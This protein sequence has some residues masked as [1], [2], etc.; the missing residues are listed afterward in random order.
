MLPV[1]RRLH[2]RSRR[3]AGE[4]WWFGWCR[5]RFPSVHREYQSRQAVVKRCDVLSWDDQIELF[6]FAIGKYNAVD[7]VVSHCEPVFRRLSLAYSTHTD[8]VSISHSLIDPKCRRDRDWPIPHFELIRG[9]SSAPSEAELQNARDQPHHCV[10]QHVNLLISRK[11]ILTM[12]PAVNLAQHYLK[13]N[14]ESSTDLKAVVLIAS[15]GVSH[16]VPWISL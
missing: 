9:T 2:R 16:I 15:M 7:I 13:V 14:R 4:S 1:R 3:G 12:A 8:R 10:I 5:K 11:N 6:E